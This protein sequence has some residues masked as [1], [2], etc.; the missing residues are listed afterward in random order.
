M[1]ISF[2]GSATATAT[3][4]AG[5]AAG[6]ATSAAGTA[7]RSTRTSRSAVGVGL[8]TIVTIMVVVLLTTFSVLALVSANS[9]LR[10]SRMATTS[11]QSY[12]QADSAAQRWLTE[13]DRTSPGEHSASFPID[14]HRSLEVTVQIMPDGSIQIQQWQSKGQ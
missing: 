12:Y 8:T 4:S 6:A 14:A 7:A 13:L 11:A 10:L 2:A 3:T 1:S 9:D 5:A